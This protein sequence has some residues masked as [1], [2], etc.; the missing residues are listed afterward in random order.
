MAKMMISFELRHPAQFGVA[1]RDVYAAAFDM[2]AWADEHGFTYASF[3]EH[4]GSD[5]GYL[6]N[7]LQV[8]AACGPITT[9]VRLRLSIVASLYDPVR[10]AEE[11][12]VADICTG[13]RLEPAIM[14]GYRPAEFAMF[15]KRLDRRKAMMDETLYV[16]EHAFRG[17][18]FEYRGTTVLVTPVPVQ[19]PMPLWLGGST[20]AVARKAAERGLRWRPPIAAMWE[21]YRQACVELGRDDPGPLAPRG[22]IF[23]WVTDGD[24]DEAW[25]RLTP[26]ILHQMNT[27]GAWTHE[28]FGRAGGPFVPKG[29][30]TDV[31]QDGAY[32]VVT[33]DEAVAI[34]QGLGDDGALYLNPLLSGIDPSDAWAMLRLFER[35]VLPAVGAAS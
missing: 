17:E 23:L 5:D 3:G 31:R 2:V 14:A 12:A 15:A 1:A 30:V 34:A 32:A 11:I 24:K 10:L 13:G 29:D 35:E 19:Q 28:A 22:T 20:V 7:P 4:H 16:L 6:P 27:Y 9:R 25:R 26:H 21:P 8:A 18:P 33:P